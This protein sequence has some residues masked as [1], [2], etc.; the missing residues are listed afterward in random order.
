V[1]A[2]LSSVRRYSAFSDRPEGGNPAGVVLDASSLD[3]ARMQEI[4]ADVGYSETAFLVAT[5]ERAYRIRYFAPLAEVA[6]CGHATIATGVALGETRGVGEYALATNSGPVGLSV[7][8][9]VR[10][11]AA[12]FESPPAGVAPL[13]APLLDRLLEHL[14]WR[15]GDLDAGFTPMIG[16]VGTRH[17]ILVARTLERL[18][19]LDYDFDALRA[20]C[21]DEGWTTIQLVVAVGEGQWRARD[22]FPFGGVV[23]DPA[24]GSGAAAFGGYLRDTGRVRVGDHLTVLQGVEMGRASTL[25]VT[26]GPSTIAVSGTAVHL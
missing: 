23:E 22:P 11:F 14:R 16:E 19:D 7:T 2:D 18:G 3:E 20:L 13:D 24:T 8:E 6:F 25:E 5:G 21:L 26:V 1:S 12:T 4:A 17:P 9:D 10:G 15:R